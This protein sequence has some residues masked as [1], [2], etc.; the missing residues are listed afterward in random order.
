MPQD[1][2]DP[3][4]QSGLCELG[5]GHVAPTLV[6]DRWS[7]TLPGVPTTMCGLFP[8]A[9]ACARTRRSQGLEAVVESSKGLQD[10]VRLLVRR[11]LAAARLL[12][13]AVLHR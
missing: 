10:C 7:T 8:S 12:G 4:R 1:T 2:L 6:L 13:A 5:P 9:T 11:T 3:Q